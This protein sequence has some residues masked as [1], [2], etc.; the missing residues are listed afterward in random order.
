VT[1]SDPAAVRGRLLELD[2]EIVTDDSD[3]DAYLRSVYADAAPPAGDAHPER[4]ALRRLE[5]TAGSEHEGSWGVVHDGVRV[6]SAGDA[7]WALSSLLW[8]VNRRVVVRS[9]RRHLLVHAATVERDG[10]AVMLVGRS[11]TGK[12][13]AAIAL[14]QLGF[15]YL[16]DDVTAIGAHGS[17]TGSPK[18]VGLRSPSI[19]VL[20][21]PRPPVVP[22]GRTGIDGAAVPVAASALGATVGSDGTVSVIVFLEP[23]RPTPELEPL[24]RGSAVTRLVEHAFDL[25]AFEGDALGVLVDAVRPATVAVAGRSSPARFAAEV[26]SLAANVTNRA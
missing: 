18:P 7:S 4:F 14:T 10:R 17:V 19:E 25:P 9:S 1:G 15:T 22:P 12:T 23:D 13:T 8:L 11:G 24:T 20:G 6:G 2:F 16:T 5:P 26:A 3:L 21:I